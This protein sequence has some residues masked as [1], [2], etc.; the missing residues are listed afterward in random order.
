M[1]HRARLFCNSFNMAVNSILT[2]YPEL[3]FE[4]VILLKCQD[5]PAAHPNTVQ[6]FDQLL[7]NFGV[8]IVQDCALNVV[9]SSD[10]FYLL[11]LVQEVPY[12]CNFA[13]KCLCKLKNCK[14][15]SAKI[16]LSRRL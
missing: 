10:F 4:L 8:D 14:R 11:N 2:K 12:Q 9:T 1:I 16:D 15:I 7:T 6:Q 13:R 5:Y 3:R